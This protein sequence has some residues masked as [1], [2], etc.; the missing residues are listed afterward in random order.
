MRRHGT[1]KRSFTALS[2]V[3]VAGAFAQGLQLTEALLDA[4]TEAFG[5]DTRMR[6]LHWQHVVEANQQG[7]DL[8]KL[9]AANQLIN[10]NRFVT[11][12]ALWG[13]DDYWATPIE[14]FGA[15][16]GDC[17]DFTLAKYFTLRAMQVD[18]DKLRVIYVNAVNL[19]QAH[20]VLGYYPAPD[21]E[22][23]VLD[24]LVRSI[25]PASMRPDLEPVYTFVGRSLW[26]A[27]MRDFAA[28]PPVRFADVFL[29]RLR[30]GAL[31]SMRAIRAPQST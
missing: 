18:E 4:A 21:A 24:N 30:Q 14:L 22:P 5:R 25:K 29:A 26:D 7:P 10:E 13:E 6:L 3:L 17:E 2:L 19:N 16:A 15:R 23:L 31:D 11:D 1:A 27:K 12:R 28:V 8:T 20:M 9:E